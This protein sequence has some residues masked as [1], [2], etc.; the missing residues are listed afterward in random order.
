MGYVSAQEGISMVLLLRILQAFSVIIQAFHITLPL[1]A[2][3][4]AILGF[5][6]FGKLEYDSV[7]PYWNLK[8][9]FEHDYEALVQETMFLTKH[10]WF[11]TWFGNRHSMLFELEC[12]SANEWLNLLQTI[13]G[14]EPP[15]SS[16]QGWCS[17]PW[18]FG[19]QERFLAIAEK[20]EKFEHL[21]FWQSCL[22]LVYL[23]T[24]FQ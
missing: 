20:H 15:V 3:S 1:P 2:G 7:S 5:R 18:T 23:C 4:G 21:C 24:L 14:Q 6:R 12:C 13:F 9:F 8:P 16:V 19:K 10:V 11:G 17:A 22:T